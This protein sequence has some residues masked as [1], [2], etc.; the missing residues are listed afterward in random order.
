MI[1]EVSCLSGPSPGY[2]INFLSNPYGNIH[3]INVFEG[4]E[5][6]ELGF[7]RIQHFSLFKAI[8]TERL[9]HTQLQFSNNY[10]FI[11]C[12]YRSR[13]SSSQEKPVPKLMI[14]IIFQFLHDV[15]EPNELYLS[16]YTTYKGLGC[17][18]IQ[19]VLHLEPVTQ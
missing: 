6:T 15:K 8:N 2:L 9:V 5:Q 4:N 1:F 16:F 18:G 7:P 19:V 17:F 11:H 12:T 14:T 3:K 13:I 10:N